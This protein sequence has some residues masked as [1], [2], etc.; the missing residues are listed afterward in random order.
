MERKSCG[1]GEKHG[2]PRNRPCENEDPLDRCDNE[3]DLQAL[4]PQE[5][6]LARLAELDDGQGIGDP[7]PRDE[8]Y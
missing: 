6:L 3:R 2:P 5:S 7:V 8:R 1:R 4:P